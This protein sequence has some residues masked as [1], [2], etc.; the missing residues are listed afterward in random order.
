[1][2]LQYYHL[3]TTLFNKFNYAHEEFDAT[4]FDDENS[5]VPHQF[6]PI[7]VTLVR[8]REGAEWPSNG[9]FYYDARRVTGVCV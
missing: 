7:T 9:T 1:L 8:Q 5:M 3:N 6:A 2:N 4:F